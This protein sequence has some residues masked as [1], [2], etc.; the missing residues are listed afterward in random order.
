MIAIAHVVSRLYLSPDIAIKR[1]ERSVHDGIYVAKLNSVTSTF[2]FFFPSGHEYAEDN[3]LFAAEVEPGNVVREQK[4]Q[5]VLQ[6]RGQ[7]LCTVRESSAVQL[8]LLPLPLSFCY[9]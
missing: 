5:W 3:L 9:G 7:R 2:F 1:Q 4:L 6:Q 8:A